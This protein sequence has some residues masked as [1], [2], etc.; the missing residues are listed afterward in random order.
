[1][2]RLP[3]ARHHSYRIKTFLSLITDPTGTQW[4]DQTKRGQHPPPGPVV[5]GFPPG[6]MIAADA[7][8]WHY[9]R[10]RAC[11]CGYNNN[12]PQQPL[13]PQLTLTPPGQQ[14]SVIERSAPAPSSREGA[15]GRRSKPHDERLNAEKTLIE[16]A[17][18][19]AGEGP[20]RDLLELKL[21]QIENA[22]HIDGWLSSA[23]RHP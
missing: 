13:A 1:M 9:G 3:P 4:N 12:G 16:A 2:Q 21:R 14:L 19:S 15:S 7:T 6:V 8:K 5:C 22:L 11:S 17:L 20:Q 10:P 23:V 18:E